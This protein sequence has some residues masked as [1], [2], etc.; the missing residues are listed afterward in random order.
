MSFNS[1][2]LEGQVLTKPFK[3]PVK[4]M[5]VLT[6]QFD[7]V[8]R[9]KDTR[10]NIRVLVF[11]SI[12]NSEAYY[13]LES[14]KMGDSV[15]IQ[16]QLKKIKDKKKNYSFIVICK[17]ATKKIALDPLKTAIIEVAPS[18]DIDIDEF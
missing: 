12:Q 7:E 15:F 1:I 11:G 4:K 6:V 2:A 9:Q 3:D 5:L 10:Q 14:V 17:Y 18:E 16:G 13:T 8:K